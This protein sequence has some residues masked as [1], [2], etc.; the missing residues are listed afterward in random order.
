[1]QGYQG[2]SFFDKTT[3]GDT[4]SVDIQRAC[5]RSFY[6]PALPD[7]NWS[8]GEGHGTGKLLWTGQSCSSEALGL[9]EWWSSEYRWGKRDRSPT[10]LRGDAARIDET[11]YIV[12]L[13][14]L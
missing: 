4:T 5:C 14:I 2:L 13:P 11:R 3:D 6:H 10:F 7:L 12:T 8:D 1:M 9:P